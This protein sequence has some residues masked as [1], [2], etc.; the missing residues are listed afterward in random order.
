M[1]TGK[2]IG[3]K[4]RIFEISSILFILVLFLINISISFG[5]VNYSFTDSTHTQSEDIHDLS[6]FSTFLGGTGD[7][8]YITQ[9]HYL[10]DTVVDSEGNIVVIGRTTS[11]DF[12]VKNAYQST[13]GG[14][15]DAT[16]SKFTPTGE[17]IFSTYLGGSADDWANCVALDEDDNIIIGGVT[18]SNNFPIINA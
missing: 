11:T 2:N 15:I 7:E 17:L 14:A 8:G 9:L 3:R 18:G 12:P 5:G 4:K 10:G 1:K 16:V 6:I 13:F